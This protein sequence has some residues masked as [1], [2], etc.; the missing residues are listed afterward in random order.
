[1]PYGS[2]TVFPDPKVVSSNQEYVLSSRNREEH[3]TGVR[4]SLERAI[5]ESV[6]VTARYS[7]TRNRSNSD[8]FDYERDLFGVSVRVSL[9]GP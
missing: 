8:V 5:G 2:P 9:G 1:M 3:E 7:R 6:V 4:V